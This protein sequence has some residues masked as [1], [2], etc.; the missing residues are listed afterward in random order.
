V[1]NDV[2]DG[3]IARAGLRLAG[4]D[5]DRLVRQFAVVQDQMAGLRLA[6]A[7][8]AEPAAIYP[9]AGVGLAADNSG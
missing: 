4:D 7:R 9:A 6:E 5:Y 8:Y 3:I 2:L 1:S